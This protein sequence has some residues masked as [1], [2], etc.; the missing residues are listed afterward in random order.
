MINDVFFFEE[1]IKRPNTASNNLKI[2]KILLSD[3]GC[4]LKKNFLRA[5][6]EAREAADIIFKVFNFNF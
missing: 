5:S 4:F 2:F 6:F 1:K 3:V